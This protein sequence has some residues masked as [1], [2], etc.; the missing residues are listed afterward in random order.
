MYFHD[1]PSSTVVYGEWTD[2]VSHATIETQTVFN[3]LLI[4]VTLVDG[5][6]VSLKFIINPLKNILYIIKVKYYF[7]RT[8]ILL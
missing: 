6:N 4:K 5:Q 7:E 2:G 3:S 1:E 8:I